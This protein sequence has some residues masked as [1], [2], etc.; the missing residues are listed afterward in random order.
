LILAEMTICEMDERLTSVPPSSV[1]IKNSRAISLLL[2][3]IMAWMGKSLYFWTI[4]ENCEKETVNFVT[5]LRPSVSKST[6]NY[7][8]LN[9]R[10]L[11]KFDV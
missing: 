2:F 5:F 4:S 7:S 11:M 3:A 10:I 1:C 9:G 8:A 6:W